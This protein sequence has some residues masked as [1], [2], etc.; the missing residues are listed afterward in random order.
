MPWWT[1][2]FRL[3]G[4]GWYIAFCIIGG[5]VGGWWLDRWLGT[6]PLFILVGVLVGSIVAFYGLYKMVLPFL[7]Q[8]NS[9]D[10]S[11]GSNLTG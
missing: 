2:A 3:A 6:Q 7:K 8:A 11:N 4:L 5:I 9:Q 1:L 10:K